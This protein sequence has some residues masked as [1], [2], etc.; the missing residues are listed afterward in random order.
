MV[1]APVSG[2][3]VRCGPWSKLVG[4]VGRL[5]GR[6]QVIRV[7]MD[8]ASACRSSAAMGPQVALEDAYEWSAA[9]CIMDVG[10]GRGEMLSRGMACAG[11]ACRGILMDRPWVLDRCAG[12]KATWRC[13]R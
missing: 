8:T 9:R 1:T 6:V 2:M 13:L 4:S 5:R 12:R 10:G 7:L 11:P 3:H